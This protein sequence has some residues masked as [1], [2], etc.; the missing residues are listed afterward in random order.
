M[1]SILTISGSDNS[2]WSGLQLDHKTISEM[3]GHAL[4]AASCIVMQDQQQIMEIV[5]LPD[6]LVQKQVHNVVTCFHPK[7]VKIGWLRSVESVKM[8]RDEII[9]CPRL[10]LS[11]GILSSHG[12]PL[13]SDETV[14][15]I[16]RCLVPEA[17]LLMLR[18]SEAEKMLGVQISTDKEMQEAAESFARMGAQYVLLRGGRLIEGRLTALLYHH[19]EASFFSS[20]NI[21]GWQQHGVGGA[22]SAAIATRLAMGDD[23]PEAVRQAH[24]Y[25]HSRIVYSVKEKDQRLRPAQLYDEFMDL[26]SAHY[27]MAHDVNFYA[28][29]LSITPRYLALV[30]E[31]SV[32]KS[33][34]QIIAEY[35]L[36]A[37]KRMLENTTLSVK[38]ISVQ[39]GFSSVARFCKFFKQ[40]TEVTPGEYRLSAESLS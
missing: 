19:G 25:V 8:L 2:G 23:V 38:E 16:M 4:T 15:A 26:V 33:P 11:P 14:A 34:K 36:D 3:G 21:N 28:E 7:A 1:T 22:L 40:W 12:E 17:M 9:G 35:L 39:L 10:V 31:T 6:G 18:C 29:R 30:T 37:S 27:P 24:T 5:D 20:L 32:G 13:A